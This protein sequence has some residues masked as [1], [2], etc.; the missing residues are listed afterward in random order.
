PTLTFGAGSQL[1]STDFQE[2]NLS[3]GFSNSVSEGSLGGGQWHTGNGG[4][5]VGVGSEGT[6][7]NGGSGSNQVIELERNPGDASNLYTTVAA[8]AGDTFV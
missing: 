1:T 8:Q 2:I 7:I 6:Y 5:A 3:G 4:N